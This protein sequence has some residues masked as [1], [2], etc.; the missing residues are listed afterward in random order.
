[1]MRLYLE[2]VCGRERE[3]EAVN[4]YLWDEESVVVLDYLMAFAVNTA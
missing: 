4:I 3:E 2:T 1:M